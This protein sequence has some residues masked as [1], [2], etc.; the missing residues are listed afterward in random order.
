[1][2]CILQKSSLENGLNVSGRAPFHF[3]TFLSHSKTLKHSR[4]QSF[5]SNGRRQTAHIHNSGTGGC[6]TYGSPR[7]FRVSHSGRKFI[8]TPLM[9]YRKCVGGGPSG[10]TWPKWLPQRL[11]C[12]SVRAMPWLRSQALSASGANE[13]PRALFM[14]EG[15]ASRCLGAMPA[16]D[17]ILFGREKPP[18]FFIGMDHV[19]HLALHG[20]S[21]PRGSRIKL[22]TSRLATLSALSW[23]NSRLGSTMSPINL[24]KTSSTSSPSL[25]LTCK[26]VR[27]SRSSVVS[28]S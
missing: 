4:Q 8:A 3:S 16:H 5:R 13:C 27:A 18:P 1:V 6:P 11:Q 10:K 2:I 22:H 25:I 12:T 19:K 7:I 23:I 9:Q 28:H 26:S 20:P 24:T 21:L 14:V 15:A 17:P